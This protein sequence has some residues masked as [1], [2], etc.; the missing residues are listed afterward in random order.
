MSDVHDS[1]VVL[2][3]AIPASGV[4]IPAPPPLTIGVVAIIVSVS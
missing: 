3:D 4:A 1:D 2:V